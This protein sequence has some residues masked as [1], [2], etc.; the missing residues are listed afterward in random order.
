MAADRNGLT[1]DELA[2][3]VGMTSRNIRAHQS[4]GLLPAPEL[5]GRTGYYGQEHIA[6]L[7][8]I[9]DLQA[10]GFN[11]EAIRRIVDRSHA[12]T[13]DILDFT[14]AV[15][16]PFSDEQPEIALVSE[17][18]E[19]WGELTPELT[20]RILQLGLARPID[21]ERV[22]L[23]SPRLERVGAEFAEL[24]M[25][26][27]TA[28]ET[29]ATVKQHSEAVARAYVKLFLEHVWRPFLE[30][31]EPEEGW[32]QVRESLDRLRP[33]ATEA[34]VAVF[35]MVMTESV[36][37]AMERELKR[38]GSEDGGRSRGGRRKRR[39]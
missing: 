35:Q 18:S 15:V 1:I 7:D 2:S 3:R 5:R 38:L 23:T 27:E 14:R 19:R 22:E 10:E 37:R 24:G 17:L 31:G 25:P 39:R 34:L 29:I 12:S 30:A 26:L 36:E 4:R 28:I 11:L 16:A 6:R 21:D 32:P 20:R 33:L 13:G 9:K 8:L